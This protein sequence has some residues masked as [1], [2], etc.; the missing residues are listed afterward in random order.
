MNIWQR[1]FI[2]IRIIEIGGKYSAVGTSRLENITLTRRSRTAE[3]IAAVAQSVEKDRGL[4]IPQTSI[5][6]TQCFA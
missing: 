5:P 1:P 2:S 3:H 4:G 6:I